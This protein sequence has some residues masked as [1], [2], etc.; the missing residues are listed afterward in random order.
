MLNKITNEN[1]HSKKL[2]K[3]MDWNCLA[4]TSTG[5]Y[6]FLKCHDASDFIQA[7]PGVKVNI[8]NLIPEL[9][10]S[11]KHHVHMGPICSGSGVTSF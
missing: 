5:C 7:V 11:Q 8:R 1:T 4:R 2:I 3:H 10:P 6:C 9:M